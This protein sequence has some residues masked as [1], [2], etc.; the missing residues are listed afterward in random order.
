[1]TPTAVRR[2][3]VVVRRLPLYASGAFVV[4]TV[5]LSVLATLTYRGHGPGRT[6]AV[7]NG[8][9]WLDAWFQGDSGWYY[10]IAD[11]GY[12]YTPGHQ[13]PVA[14]FPAYPLAVRALG[15]VLGGDWSTA[16]GWVTLISALGAVALFAD[17]ARTRLP[18]RTAVVAVAL[19]L[20]YPY[21]FFLYGTGYSDAL[22]LLTT[23]G[24]FALLERRHFVLAGLVGILATGGRPTGVAVLIALVVR[25]LEMLAEERAARAAPRVPVSVTSG[26]GGVREADERPE[27][28]AG[29]VPLRELCGAV[30]L[31]RWRQLA[32]LVSAA[33][34]LGWMV[35]L[36]VRFGDPLAFV[37]VQGAPGWDQGSGPYTWFK[38]LFV[39]TVLKGMWPTLTLLAP[40]AL[41]CLAGVLLVPTA[42][43]RF[44]WGYAAFAVVSI[45]IPIIGTKDFMGAGRYMLVAFPLIGAAAVVLT[46]D[47]RPRW[48]APAAL[49][50][51]AVGLCIATVAYV[52]GV[53]VS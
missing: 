40:Q 10:R 51:A 44:G 45:S 31:V 46:G 28:R 2:W 52:S 21:S 32:V 22:F 15:L 4:L 33:G 53:E 25:A 18:P 20:L 48:L 41:A 12:F 26:R 35:Y 8:P 37:T 39:A 38:A 49:G 24:S 16:A 5:F 29:P 36:G 9:A 43:R 3:D 13:S 34:L 23:L 30:R 7:L 1:M 14:F 17:W 27:R 47:R 11:S 50:L 6:G 42:W 19:L